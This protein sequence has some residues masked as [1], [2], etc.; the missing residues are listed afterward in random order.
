MRFVRRF[1]KTVVLNFNVHQAR[2]GRVKDSLPKERELLKEAFKDKDFY[3][4]DLLAPVLE[5]IGR[6]KL[7]YGDWESVIA[8]AKEHRPTLLEELGPIVARL[9]RNKA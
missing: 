7:Y 1:W 4:R 5:F 6:A 3:D 9:M 8:D 2:A